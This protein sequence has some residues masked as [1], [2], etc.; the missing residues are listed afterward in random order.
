[1]SLPI[2][3]MRPMRLIPFILPFF[4]LPLLAV[5]FLTLSA[6]VK[7]QDTDGRPTKEAQA[8]LDSLDD[9]DTL[10]SIHPLQLTPDQIDKLIATVTAAKLDY[11]KKVTALASDPVLKMADEIHETHKQALAGK[12]SSKEFD[13]KIKKI[14]S[15]F[16]ARRDEL[17]AQNINRL[18]ADVTKIFNA[19]QRAAA[20]K[21]EKDVL[22]KLNRYQTGT[23]DNKMFNA[24]IVDIFINTVRIV[25]LLKDL[26]TAAE[27]KEKP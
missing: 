23:P 12:I 17:N 2:A 15:D 24:Y 5:G 10:R 22:V 19:S 3:S 16:L 4:L 21:M 14:Q 13:D 27:S 1:M 20:I 25:P 11:D 9:I 6:P 18:N 8:L 7:A 26:K